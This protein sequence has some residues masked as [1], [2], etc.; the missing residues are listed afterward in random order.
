MIANREDGIWIL[1]VGLI[2][3]AMW[4]PHTFYAIRQWRRERTARAF[5]NA[6]IAI[7]LLV[8]LS[9][10]VLAGAARLWPGTEWIQVANRGLTPVLFLFLITGAMVAWWT[11]RHVDG[12]W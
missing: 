7:M 6:F 10:G 4:A 3:V 9:R 8:G 2:V 11:W 1:A 12:R 5:R